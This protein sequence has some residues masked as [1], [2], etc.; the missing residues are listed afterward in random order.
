MIVMAVSKSIYL[1]IVMMFICGLANSGRELV[2]YIYGSEFLSEKWRVIYGT[3]MMVIDG[4]SISI[5]AI[6]FD[7]ISKRAIYFESF[8][9]A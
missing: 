3:M 9:I 8:A 4:L 6:Y 2:G 7:Y 1:T 5:S